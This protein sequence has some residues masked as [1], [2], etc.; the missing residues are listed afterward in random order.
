MYIT[1]IEKSGKNEKLRI[2]CCTSSEASNDLV[3]VSMPRQ[4][5][6]AVQTAG[7]KAT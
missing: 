7:L 4:S 1:S 5:F 6:T 2:L 3:G